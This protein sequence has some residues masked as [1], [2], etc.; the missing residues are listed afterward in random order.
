[1]VSEILVSILAEPEASLAKRAFVDMQSQAF[2]VPDD[3]DTSLSQPQ[4]VVDWLPRRVL[5]STD[6]FEHLSLTLRGHD[7]NVNGS[8][9]SPD[10]LWMVSGSSDCTLGMWETST[11][12]RLAKLEG[13]N[14]WVR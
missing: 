9:W 3:L 4:T 11:G 8:S 5:W 13:H 1:M 2:L 14:D 7:L 12:K 10:N 6:T